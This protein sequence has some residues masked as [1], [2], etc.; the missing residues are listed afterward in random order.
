MSNYIRSVI[1]TY[2]CY[3]HQRWFFSQKKKKVDDIS[4][5]RYNPKFT[6]IKNFNYELNKNFKNY[7]LNKHN[8]QNA[9]YIKYPLILLKILNF[10]SNL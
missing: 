4:K 10:I 5:N 1:D 7:E 3:F 8:T 6:I 9:K 2:F